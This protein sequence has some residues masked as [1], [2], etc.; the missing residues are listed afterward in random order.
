MISEKSLRFGKIKMKFQKIRKDIA[1]GKSL[2]RKIIENCNTILYIL[3]FSQ[4][5]SSFNQ[6]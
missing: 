2:N 1:I 4:K 6:I 3:K 5:H